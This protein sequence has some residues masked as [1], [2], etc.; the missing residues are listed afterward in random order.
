[1]KKAEILKIPYL[2]IKIPKNKKYGI[3]ADVINGILIADCYYPDKAIPEAR[4]AIDKKT[5]IIYEPETDSWHKKGIKDNYWTNNYAEGILNEDI[6]TC[7]K[8]IKKIRTYGNIKHEY[9]NKTAFDYIQE[10]ID[11]Y[12]RI[13]IV[14]KRNKKQKELETRM[15]EVENVHSEGFE[16]WAEI[17]LRQKTKNYIYYKR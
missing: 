2:Y 7:K 8:D 13:A 14:E 16:K 1:M 17:L 3:A 5:W 11:N 15:A 6:H 12:K 10:I 4:I 9:C